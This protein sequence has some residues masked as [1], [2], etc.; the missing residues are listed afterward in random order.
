MF[1]FEKLDVY[2]EI[3]MI[4]GKTLKW[5]FAKKNAD[6]YLVDQFKRA[7]IGSL[8][9]LAEGTG[10]MTAPDKKRFYISARASIFECTAILQTLLDLQMIEESFYQELYEGY[11]KISRMLLGMIRSLE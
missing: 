2:Q 6:L 4:N 5:L 8:L 1:D 9:N 10:R 3:R 7:S 11:E